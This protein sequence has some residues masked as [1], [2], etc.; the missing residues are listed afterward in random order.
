MEEQK[1]YHHGDLR[2]AL[3]RAALE[4]LDTE[5]LSA[6]SLRAAAARAG[7]SHAAPK[8]H[9]GNMQ[10]LV[11]AVIAHGYRRLD[12]MM[13]EDRAE[14]SADLVEKVRKVYEMPGAK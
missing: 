5:G 2:G 12:A 8:H 14:R 6:L 13:S 1:R 7:V 3:I 10:G 9:F 11:G 4:I